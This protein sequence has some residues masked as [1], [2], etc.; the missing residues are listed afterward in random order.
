MSIATD[1][2]QRILFD[3]ITDAVVIVDAQRPGFPIIDANQAYRELLPDPALALIGEPWAAAVPRSQEQGLLDI[4]ARVAASGEPFQARDFPYRAAIGPDGEPQPDEVRYW[5]WQC[6]PLGADFGA[7]ERLVVILADV[8]DR[9]HQRRARILN[10]QIVAQAP[11][12]VLITTGIDHRTVLVSPRLAQLGDQPVVRL[13]GQPIFAALPALACAGLAPLMAEVYATGRPFVA[14]EYSFH[15]DET[16]EPLEWS[17]TILPL[18]GLDGATEGLMLMVADLTA[19]VQ[20]RRESAALAA[21]AQRRAG[22]LEA[23]IGALTDGVF[24]LDTQGRVVEA[25]AAGRQLL[26][27]STSPHARRFL[28]VLVDCELQWDDG[29]P[30]HTGDALLLAAFGGLRRAEDLVLVKG[31]RYL[32]FCATPIVGTDGRVS[33]AVALVRDITPQRQAEQEKDTFLSLIAHEVKSPLTAIK[34]FAQ[35]ARRALGGGPGQGNERAA[36]HLEVIDQQ[37]ARIGRLVDELSDVNR[38]RKGTL[39]ITPLACDLVALATTTVAQQ[40][41]ALGTH[42]IEFVVEASVLPVHA[43]PVRIEQVL[44]ILLLN[45]ATYSP[46]AERIAVTVGR[47]GEDALLTVRDQGIGIPEADRARIFDRFFRASN[48]GDSGHGGLGLGLYI[49]HEIIARSGGR[50][51]AESTPGAGSSFHIALPR[52]EYGSE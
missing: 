5:D 30:L 16:R 31:R 27:L 43:D 1:E 46:A 34:G 14:E 19:Q 6:L 21:A 18:P 33:G 44:A 23:V 7:V 25:N 50:I 39:A 47:A 41:A 38:L 29:R 3:H 13:T 2:L 22:E 37:V 24:L 28:E 42:Q 20:A 17:L 12:G 15:L 9:L 4:F 26:G 10:R 40:Q 49:A 8:T 32:C 36:R 48:V 45:A 51:W 11:V 52:A 35:L